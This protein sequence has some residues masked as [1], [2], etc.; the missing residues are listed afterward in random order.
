MNGLNDFE[1]KAWEKYSVDGTAISCEDKEHCCESFIAGYRAANE[2]QKAW[3]AEIIKILDDK[4]ASNKQYVNAGIDESNHGDIH[5]Q[6]Q[7]EGYESGL[8][9][10]KAILERMAGGK[11]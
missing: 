8:L 1:H 11:A 7:A 4:L 2:E 3:A 6:A 5:D 9:E 10:A